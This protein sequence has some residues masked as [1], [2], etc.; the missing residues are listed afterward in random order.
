M[1]TLGGG[2]ARWCHRNIFEPRSFTDADQSLH[3][4]D[5]F[6]QIFHRHTASFSLKK[7][8]FLLVSCD[9]RLSILDIF[10]CL[11]VDSSQPISFD[12]PL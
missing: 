7:G 4:L 6:N 12:P 3:Y 8:K 5:K 9:N 2:A 1:L 10:R 11:F